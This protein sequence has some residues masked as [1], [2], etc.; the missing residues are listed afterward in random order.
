MRRQLF[1]QPDLRLVVE[2]RPRHVDELLRLLGDGLD[3]LGVADAGRVDGDAGR[4]VEKAIAVDVLDDR[5][6]AAGDDERIVARVGRRH[7]FLVAFDDRPGLRA[8]K[9][10]VDFR[11]LHAGSAYFFFYFF[12]QRVV[13]PVSSRMMPWLSRSL[14]M[15]SASAK[16]RARRASRLAAISRS[17]SSTGTGGCSS[18]AFRSAR[19]P[20]TGRTARTC[21]EPPRRPLRPA[22]R[23]RWRC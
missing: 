10:R 7:E 22:R 20:S 17:I 21:R 8:R 14:R 18:S 16:L 11:G 2:V 4:A 9:R 6:L 1:G 15:R 5:A 13:E 19:T 3:D 23:R 12:F